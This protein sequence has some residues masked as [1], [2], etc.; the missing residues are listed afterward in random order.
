[1]NK[2]IALLLLLVLLYYNFFK[3]ELF[4][5]ETTSAS[6]STTA[7]STTQSLSFFELSNAD[8]NKIN[9]LERE[10]EILNIDREEQKMKNDVGKIVQ[11]AKNVLAY[12]DLNMQYFKDI[13]FNNEQNEQTNPVNSPE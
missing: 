7:A 11:E 3:I 6:D 8:K 10:K 4:A 2:I 9:K 12:S 5:G 13:K 1:M